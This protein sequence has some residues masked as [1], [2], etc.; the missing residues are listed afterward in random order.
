MKF[1]HEE[2]I[3]VMNKPVISCIVPVYNGER[4]LGE[5]LESILC[6]TYQNIEVIVVDDGSTDGTESMARKYSRRVRYHY[7]SNAGAPAARDE[8][9]RLSTGE[10]VA[11]LDADDLW[12]SEKLEHQWTRFAAKPELDL[13]FTH[14][15]HFWVAEMED[16]AKQ[17]QNHRLSQR[18]PSYLTQALLVRRNI[19]KQVGTFNVGLKFADAKD[20]ILRA[21][22][23]GAVMEMLPEVLWYR[24]MHQ[25]NHSMESDTRQMTKQMQEALLQV[26]RSSLLRRRAQDGATPR[27]YQF[28]SSDWKN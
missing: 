11:F 13:C 19:F 21:A 3:M 25:G 22:H 20:W 18:L 4:F 27:A 8:G 14:V 9:I 26:V 2:D 15:E 1:A 6:Q 23:Q 16:E 5:A 24:R 12:H 10:L 7:Q 28:P 17:F